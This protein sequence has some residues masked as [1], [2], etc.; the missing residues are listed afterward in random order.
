M[1]LRLAV[2]GL[3]L[4]LQGCVGCGDSSCKEKR[5][6]QTTPTLAQG[7]TTQFS[8]GC[9]TCGHGYSS[10]YWAIVGPDSGALP[11][12]TG[13]V[14]I[15]TEASCDNPLCCQP[16]RQTVPPLM[17]SVS[18]SELGAKNLCGENKPVTWTVRVINNSNIT[19]YDVGMNVSCPTGSSGS[20]M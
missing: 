11:A 19:L 9:S 20:S 3:S 14:T 17:G 18:F 13:S 4:L 6:S 7:A 2:V 8:A 15:E 12:I 5:S 16:R 10:A 1:R